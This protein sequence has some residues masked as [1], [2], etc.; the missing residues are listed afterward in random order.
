MLFPNELFC[1]QDMLD[2][3]MQG[4]CM[5]RKYSCI[6]VNGND[7]VGKG[8]A[9]SLDYRDCIEYGS[10]PRRNNQEKYTDKAEFFESCRVIHAEMDAILSA[11]D[12][13]TLEGAD[14]YLLGIYNDQDIYRD[15]FPCDICLRHI[16]LVGI[17][18]ILV[19]ISREEIKKYS[20]V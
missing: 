18:Q 9:H 20:V 15:A 12:L 16:K 17:N 10:C 19:F 14:L 13:S 6:I 1:F 2:L 3:A 5:Y 11:K 8:Y 7:I 4:N